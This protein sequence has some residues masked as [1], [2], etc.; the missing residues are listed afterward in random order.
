ME[1]FPSRKLRIV[2]LL[3]NRGISEVDIFIRNTINDVDIFN[4]GGRKRR[5]CRI[6][7]V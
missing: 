2:K 5:I 1:D 7:G 4:C 6:G 3:F